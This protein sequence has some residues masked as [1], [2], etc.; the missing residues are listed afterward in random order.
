MKTRS[1][2]LLK[3]ILA[4]G[5]VY[6]GVFNISEEGRVFWSE[7]TQLMYPS[8]LRWPVGLGEIAAAAMLFWSYSERLAIWGL[9]LIMVGAVVNNFPWDIPT[10]I[11]ESRCL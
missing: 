4:L 3:I 1:R 10:S 9:G 7:G 11:W 2:L 6:H 5:F 8:Y